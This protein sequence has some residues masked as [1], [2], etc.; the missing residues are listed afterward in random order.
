MRTRL[1]YLPWSCARTGACFAQYGHW[2]SAHAMI[3]TGAFVL[4][5]QMG[6]DF[7][8]TFSEET[9][10]VATTATRHAKAS[11]RAALEIEVRQD[12]AADPEYRAAT[13]P[14]MAAALREALAPGLPEEAEPQDR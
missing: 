10:L 1:P 4:Y 6:K 11:G 3:V 7:L 14:L 9:A 12:L 13:V 5:P 8:P 2:K